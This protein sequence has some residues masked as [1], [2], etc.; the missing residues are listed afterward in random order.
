MPYYTW[1]PNSQQGYS[2]IAS[3]LYTNLTTK[4]ILLDFETAFSELRQYHGFSIRGVGGWAVHG[5][6]WEAKGGLKNTGTEPL[7]LQ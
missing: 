1:T 2:L 7:C 4:L 6:G 5:G 3:S